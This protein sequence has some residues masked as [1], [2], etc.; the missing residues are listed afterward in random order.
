MNHQKLCS[1]VKSI[2]WGYILIHLHLNLGTIDILPDFA[3]YLLILGALPALGQPEPS[4]L[5]LKPFCVGL[6]LWNLY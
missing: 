6:V 4:A 2:A 3:G 1:A 5:L